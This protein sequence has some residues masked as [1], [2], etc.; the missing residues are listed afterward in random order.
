MRVDS[1]EYSTFKRDVVDS[2]NRGIPV[3]W[4]LHLGL[5][6]EDQIEGSYEANR[7]AVTKPDVGGEDKELAEL[8]KRWDEEDKARMAKMREEMPRPPEYMQGGHMRLIVGYDGD[9]GV[10]F[11]TDSWGPG[12]ELKKMNIEEAFAATHAIMTIEPR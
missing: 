12:H 5:F 6:W 2:I 7:Y 11:Y 4:A 1:R 9:E 3:M 8:L 10:L